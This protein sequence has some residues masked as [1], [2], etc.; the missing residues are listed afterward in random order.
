MRHALAGADSWRTAC[1]LPIDGGGIELTASRLTD[2]PAC[3]A[4]IVEAFL[5][6]NPQGRPTTAACIVCGRY[7]LWRLPT[8][9]AT[10]CPPCRAALLALYP[11][12]RL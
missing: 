9:S 10:R 12:R 4:A 6:P 1:G 11:A 3:Q 2:C 5:L 8:A 7:Y